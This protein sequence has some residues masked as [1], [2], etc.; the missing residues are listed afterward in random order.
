MKIKHFL[1]FVIGR[2][3]PFE[4]LD[5]RGLVSHIGSS[6]PSAHAAAVFSSLAV[7]DKEFRKFKWIWLGIA[8]LVAFSRIYLGVHYLS[9]VAFGALVGLGSGLFAV[10]FWEKKIVKNHR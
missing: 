3:R 7:L 2:A 8:F 4:L 6:F 10:W 5:I 9:D 1:K